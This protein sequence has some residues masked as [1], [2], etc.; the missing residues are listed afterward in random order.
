MG[1]VKFFKP[2]LDSKFNPNV[3]ISFQKLW[4]TPYNIYIRCVRFA[5]TKIR[6]IPVPPNL[7]CHTSVIFHQQLDD[8][9]SLKILYLNN[10]QNLYIQYETTS[11]TYETIHHQSLNNLQLQTSSVTQQSSPFSNPA[12]HISFL[13]RFSTL[14]TI[15]TLSFISKLSAMTKYPRQCTPGKSGRSVKSG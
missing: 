3:N 5:A 15:Y 7:I 8:F 10:R 6:R 12:H 14:T 2:F 1:E 4:I 13:C 11:S 9:S